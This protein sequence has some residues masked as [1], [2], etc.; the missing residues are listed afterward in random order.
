MVLDPSVNPFVC[1]CATGNVPASAL[2]PEESFNRP[3][4]FGIRPKLI[5]EP[6][7]HIGFQAAACTL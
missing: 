2:V 1:F 6:L 4:P 5:N 7:S 3:L